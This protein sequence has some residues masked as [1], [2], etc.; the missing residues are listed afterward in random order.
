MNISFQVPALPVAQ[1]RQR[2]RV[3]QSN[4]K[5]FA[6]NYTPA[7]APINDFKATVRLAASEAYKGAPLDAPLGVRLVFVFP[8]VGKSKDP[9]RKHKTT[10]PDA[11]N[12]A[13]G[14][15]DSLNGLLWTDDKLIASLHAT[16]MTASLDEQ[17]HVEVDVWTL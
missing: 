13:K 4:G 10:K 7:K 6:S 1:P 5:A 16:K 15:M 3:I 11:D 8:R 14:I 17:P 12:L 2:Q 9:L